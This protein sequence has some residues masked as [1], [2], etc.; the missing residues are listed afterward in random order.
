M[1]GGRLSAC[2]VLRRTA[3]PDAPTAGAP[4]FRPLS[5]IGYGAWAGPW[6]SLGALLTSASA[7]GGRRVPTQACQPGSSN[8]NGPRA[9]VF[10]V[11]LLG[12]GRS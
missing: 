9:I 7:G 2:S 1:A 4:G 5:H 12:I 10:L 6:L 8:A 3:A 11:S